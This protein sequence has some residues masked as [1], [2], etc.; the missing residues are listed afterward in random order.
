MKHTDIRDVMEQAEY[1]GK[2]VTVCGWVRTSRDSKTMAFAELND[3]TTF[4]HIQIVINKNEFA[5]GEEL[6]ACDSVCYR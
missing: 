3:G 2:E 6:P 1:S 4:K 5:Q